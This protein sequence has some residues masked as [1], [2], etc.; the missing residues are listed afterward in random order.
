MRWR[1]AAGIVIAGLAVAYVGDYMTAR[2]RGDAIGTVKVEQYY[3]IPLKNGQTEYASAGNKSVACAETL[4]P[5]FGDRPCWYVRRH[6][7]EWIRP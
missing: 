5:H 4:F 3:A 7:Q 2:V 1:A 6:N